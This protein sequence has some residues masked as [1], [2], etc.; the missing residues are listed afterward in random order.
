[1]AEIIDDTAMPQKRLNPPLA[2]VLANFTASLR[3]ILLLELLI[4]KQ[5]EGVVGYLFCLL[6]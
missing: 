2:E 3:S 4:C 6:K 1:M 5:Y